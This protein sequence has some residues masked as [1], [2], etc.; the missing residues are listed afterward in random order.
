M[1]DCMKGWKLKKINDMENLFT[2]FPDLS[3]W[4]KTLLGTASTN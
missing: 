4:G 1:Y 2:S 3:F